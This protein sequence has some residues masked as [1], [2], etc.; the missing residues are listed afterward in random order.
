ME[1]PRRSGSLVQEFSE[2]EFEDWDTHV[3]PSDV[4]IKKQ[5]WYYAVWFTTANKKHSSVHLNLKY[6]QRTA[7][8][9]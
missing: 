8:E 3:F 7:S 6:T 4:S 5:Q 2:S 9:L 1:F